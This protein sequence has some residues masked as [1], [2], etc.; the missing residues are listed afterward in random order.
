MTMNK[1]SLYKVALAVL[2]LGLVTGTSGVWLLGSSAHGAPD[3][4]STSTSTADSIAFTSP[5]SGASFTGT[6]TYT[7][8]GTISPAPPSRDNV[9]PLT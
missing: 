6:Q 9:S 1:R 5:S 4:T 3:Q 2:L 8:S 7:I